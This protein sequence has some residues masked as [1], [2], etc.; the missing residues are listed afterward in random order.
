[1]NYYTN[2]ITKLDNDEVFVFGANLQGFHGAGSAG[3]AT[4]SGETNH[5]ANTIPTTSH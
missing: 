4:F 2:D 3:F 1:M 5:H